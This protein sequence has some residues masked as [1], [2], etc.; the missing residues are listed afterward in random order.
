MSVR[1]ASFFDRL[2]CYQS[3]ASS[4]LCVGIDPDPS[5]VNTSDGV[6]AFC[7]DLIK[8]TAPFVCAFKLQA[9]CFAA[10][11]LEEEL[12]RIVDF[13]HLNYPDISVILDSK[14]GDVPSTSCWYAREC[15]GRYSAD[16]TTVQP[17]LGVDAILPFSSYDEDGHRGVFVLCRTSNFGAS[18]LQER[19]LEDG[20]PVYMS[21]AKMVSK[22]CSSYNNCGLVVGATCPDAIAQV[23]HHYP[24]LWLLIPGVGAQGGSL[25][26][27]MEITGGYR[28][29]VTVSRSVSNPS[30]FFS[31]KDVTS[32]DVALMIRDQI[33]LGKLMVSDEK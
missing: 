15:F 27:V 31:D 26:R 12:R 11:A 2:G 29:L 6:Y 13:I 23:R 18:D 25:E 24:D 3:Q 7:E 19:R 33:N 32:A 4:L 22:F 5:V 28:I 8:K 21:V 20:L 1:S 16:A 10:N 9:A 17:Y 14:R 30:R